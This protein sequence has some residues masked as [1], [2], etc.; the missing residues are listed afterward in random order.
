MFSKL[1][2]LVIDH[3]EINLG[4]SSIAFRVWLTQ[5]EAFVNVHQAGFGDVGHYEQIGDMSL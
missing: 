4:L 1:D 5:H 3:E 2:T